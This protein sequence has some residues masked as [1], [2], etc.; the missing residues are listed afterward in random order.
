MEK[1]TPYLD[2]R[3]DRSKDYY[4]AVDS[5]EDDSVE[6]AE[7]G[8]SCLVAPSAAGQSATLPSSLESAGTMSANQWPAMVPSE[9]SPPKGITLPRTSKESLSS[10]PSSHPDLTDSNSSHV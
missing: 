9:W 2:L 6:V 7:P 3:V 1:D 4:K 5:S 8:T 10:Q